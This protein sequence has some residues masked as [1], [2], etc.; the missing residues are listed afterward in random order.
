MVQL[1][2]VG[3]NLMLLLINDINDN[4]HLDVSAKTSGDVSS[5]GGC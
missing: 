2:L 3:L 5:S 1:K 4:D